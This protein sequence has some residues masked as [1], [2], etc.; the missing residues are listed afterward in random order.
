[1]NDDSMLFEIW[2]IAGWDMS[3]FD[4][5]LNDDPF[6]EGRSETRA[7]LAEQR[8]EL[9]HVF[10]TH[11]ADTERIKAQAD[12][13]LKTAECTAMQIEGVRIATILK[14]RKMQAKGAAQQRRPGGKSKLRKKI[15]DAMRPSSREKRPFKEFLRA[16]ENNP[17]DGLSIGEAHG[18]ASRYLVTD[19]ESDSETGSYSF[20]TLRRM[21]SEA[22]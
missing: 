16:W 10:R 9:V 6:W 7:Y 3:G 21:Y 14:T 8:E 13:L 22:G 15:I 17:H 12:L 1:M 5:W 19:E 2:A 11:Y 4:E 20:E 18:D